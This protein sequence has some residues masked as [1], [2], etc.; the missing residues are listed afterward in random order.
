MR[1]SSTALSI[2]CGPIICCYVVFAAC[3]CPG[4]LR[5]H[6]ESEEKKRFERRQKVAP[7]PLPVRPLENNLTIPVPHSRRNDSE[8]SEPEVRRS[9]R[10]MILDQ[11]QSPLMRLPLELR[12]MIYKAVLGN[13]TMHMILKEN[14]LGHLRCKAPSAL[15]CPL[16]YNGRTLSRECCWGN[17]DSSNIWAPKSGANEPTDGN[18][19]PFLRTC[20]QMYVFPKQFQ[21]SQTSTD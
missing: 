1:A 8:K 10:G 9:G 2:A 18:I 3:F 11:S 16:G 21:L 12:E 5:R 19:V 14:K 17:V 7:R 13:N 20:R 15:E 4:R 6:T